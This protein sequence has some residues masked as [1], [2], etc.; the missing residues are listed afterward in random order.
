MY[1]CVLCGKPLSGIVFIRKEERGTVVAPND[2]ESNLL[3]PGY[4]DSVEKLHSTT[5][6][7]VNLH[8]SHF[9]TTVSGLLSSQPRYSPVP[10]MDD[11]RLSI[12]IQNW[13]IFSDHSLH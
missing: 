3:F 4:C 8:W 11:C 7:G 9:Q 5:E 1:V 2:G 6:F 13:M 12:T 10:K